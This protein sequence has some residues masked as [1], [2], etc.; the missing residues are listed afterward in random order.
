[1]LI[2]FVGMVSGRGA[3]IYYGPAKGAGGAVVAGAVVMVA[4]VTKSFKRHCLDSHVKV[5][6]GAKYS[7]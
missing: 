6:V 7:K 3:V 1:M 4:G 5:Q 2:V